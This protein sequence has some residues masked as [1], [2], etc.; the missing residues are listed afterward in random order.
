MIDIAVSFYFYF[1]GVF[2]LNLNV[3]LMMV[4]LLMQWFLSCDVISK[5]TFLAINISLGVLWCSGLMNPLCTL[6]E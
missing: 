2:E 3:K 6:M 1:V 5:H 4:V